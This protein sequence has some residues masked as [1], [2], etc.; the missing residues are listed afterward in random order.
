M[1]RIEFLRRIARKALQPIELN[2]SKELN[3]LLI[4]PNFI[5]EVLI[6]GSWAFCFFPGRIIRDGGPN[7]LRSFM[8]PRLGKAI[9]WM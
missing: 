8:N 9:S 2:A 5:S 4:C 1:I 7:L 3:L 6:T